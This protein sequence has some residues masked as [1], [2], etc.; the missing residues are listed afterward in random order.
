MLFTE[1][2]V[3]QI[4]YWSPFLLTLSDYKIYHLTP[5]GSTKEKGGREMYH[6]RLELPRVSSVHTFVFDHVWSD[7]TSSEL[8][9]ESMMRNDL[10][11]SR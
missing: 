2:A 8:H 5:C 6:L 4:S 9:Q 7:W 10:T 1:L 11:Q 3:Q